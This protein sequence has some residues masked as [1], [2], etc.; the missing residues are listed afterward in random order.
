MIRLDGLGNVGERMANK[1]LTSP[2][3]QLARLASLLSFWKA[4]KQNALLFYTQVQTHLPFRCT[5][6]AIINPATYTAILSRE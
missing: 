1:A 3:P 2:M 5:N 4:Q 6:Q